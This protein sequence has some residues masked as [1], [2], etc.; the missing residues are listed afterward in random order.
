MA[1]QW[2]ADCVA[3]QS[4]NQGRHKQ[5]LDQRGCVGTKVEADLHELM[6]EAQAWTVVVPVHVAVQAGTM[7]TTWASSFALQLL[8]ANWC[9]HAVLLP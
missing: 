9:L 8:L 7:N 6:V 5:Q 1:A 2:W 3:Q 4:V